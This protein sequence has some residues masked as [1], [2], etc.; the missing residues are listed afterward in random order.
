LALFHLS[1]DSRTERPSQLQHMPE[2]WCLTLNDI[3][4]IHWP[5]QLDYCKSIGIT[6]LQ[7]FSITKSYWPNSL[8]SPVD[9]IKVL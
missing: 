7:C 1:S 3:I 4:W 8:T 2:I 6:A 9:L 5:H